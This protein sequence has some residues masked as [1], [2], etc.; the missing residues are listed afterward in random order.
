[1]KLNG[2]QIQEAIK[3]LIAEY[4]FDPIQILNIVKMGI[5]TAYRKDYLPNE[6]KAQVHVSITA[7]GTIKIY[8]EYAVVEE[9]EDKE[10]DKQLLL[11]DAKKLKE[12][13]EIDENIMIEITPDDLEFTRI[14]VT[15]AAQTIKQNLKNIERE[16]FFEKFQDR[17]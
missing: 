7:D 9:I 6:R 16:R 13:A 4:K 8:R 11:K 1:M 2:L 15:A 5:R 3:Q 12:D 14:G 10:E 17:Q